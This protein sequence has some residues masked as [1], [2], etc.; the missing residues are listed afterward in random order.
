MNRCGVLHL[1]GNR[2]SWLDR[3]KM[4]LQSEGFSQH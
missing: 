4:V 2:K 1:K 3:L